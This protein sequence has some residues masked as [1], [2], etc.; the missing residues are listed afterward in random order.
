MYKLSVNKNQIVDSLGQPVYLRG[1][2]VG[3]WMNMENFI[4]G[5][6]GSE[7]GI[8][9]ALAHEIGE[10]KAQIF[11]DRWLDYFF[12]EEDVAYIASLGANVVRLALNYR[13]FESDAE[14]FKYRAQGFARLERIVKLCAKHDVYVI[15]DLHAVQ[16]WQSPDWHCDNANAPALF[17]MHPHFQ[18]RW[19]ALWQE[20]ARRYK[21]N[22]TIAGYD[23]VNEPLSDSPLRV[24]TF[25]TI[26]RL[27]RRVV[28]AIRDVG[29]DHIIFLE[30]NNFGAHLNGFEPPFADNLVYSGHSY[31]P[32]AS[33]PGVYP[34]TFLGHYFD[35]TAMEQSHLQHEAAQYAQKYNVPL[36]IG[37]FGAP[38]NGAANEVPYR[39]CALDD[40]ITAFEKHWHHWTI[41]TYKDVGVMGLMMVSPQ[42]EYLQLNAHVLDLKFQLEADAWM[43]WLPPS[44][45]RIKMNELAAQIQQTIGDPGI[46]ELLVRQNLARGVMT[47]L[48]STL[49]EPL[50]AKQFRGMSEDD[51]DRILQSFAFR[52]CTPH[53][54]L[55]G[56]VKRHLQ[57]ERESMNAM[58]A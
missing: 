4:N 11:F 49:L 23:V 18:E 10:G 55:T 35:A 26:N 40:Q 38:V 46:S 5:Y 28:Q 43:T 51:L 24:E 56:V 48:I 13:H 2:C 6:P 44:T 42:S 47:N 39:L 25:G 9:E 36:W 21:D 8:R 7:H 57:S 58:T 12:A 14:P 30:G 45:T 52:N 54:G 15:L 22:A 37:E 17:W 32:A 16:G 29:D 41:W 33:E 3:G 1:V 27:Y 31:S 34:G 19:I 53:A 50:W 20:L